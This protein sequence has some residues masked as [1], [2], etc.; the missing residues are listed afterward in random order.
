MFGEQIV[1]LGWYSEATKTHVEEQIQKF[2]SS[3][4]RRG[5]PKA[6]RDITIASCTKN[7]Q[8]NKQLVTDYSLSLTVG[9]SSSALTLE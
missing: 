5:G 6:F 1:A 9:Y 8:L 7:V 3:L 2:Y 4:K